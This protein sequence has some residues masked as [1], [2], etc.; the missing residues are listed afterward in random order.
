MTGQILHN[1]YSIVGPPLSEK[2]STRARSGSN[3]TASSTIVVLSALSCP[4]LIFAFALS[5]TALRRIGLLHI[6]VRILI[7]AR[8]SAVECWMISSRRSGFR[9]L[10]NIDN[11][12]AVG[13][14]K[15]T[16]SS[17]VYMSKSLGYLGHA[18]VWVA[19]S[20]SGCLRRVEE[21]S[22]EIWQVARRRV[23]SSANKTGRQRRTCAERLSPSFASFSE[24]PGSRL[25]IMGV[26]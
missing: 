17:C 15:T 2:S 14:M 24:Q 11:C 26:S 18:H 5:A 23:S 10:E 19:R 9:I 3:F 7:R 1:E 13:V 12:N 20:F 16:Y 25:R 4:L 8:D 21:R 22:C 6:F